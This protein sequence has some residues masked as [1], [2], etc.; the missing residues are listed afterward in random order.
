V[1]TFII[2]NTMLKQLI[3][4]GTTRSSDG[5]ATDDSIRHSVRFTVSED[6]NAD[7]P[8]G[9][10]QSP[11]PSSSNSPLIPHKDTMQSRSRSDS[12]GSSSPGSK[13]KSLHS[14]NLRSNLTRE[15]HGRD[16]LF[17]YEIVKTLGVG[18]MGSVARVKRRTNVVG[19]SARKDVQEAVRRQKRDKKCLDIPII[20]GLFR[21]CL[22]G[23]LR[24]SRHGS[25][26]GLTSSMGESM[27]SWFPKMDD[28]FTSSNG[29]APS[30]PSISRSDSHN[31]LASI[32][33]TTASGHLIQYAMKSIHLNR[34]QDSAFLTEL[35]N[36]IAILKQLDHPHIVRAIETFEHRNQI[37]IVMELCSG[38]DLYSRDPYTEEDCARIV[39]SILSAIAYMH[40]KNIL[41]RDLKFENV[42]FVNDHPKA[43]IKL[44]DFG[45][46][47]VYG[48]N[49]EL[50]EGVGTIYTMAPEVL[51]GD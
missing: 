44:I 41:H 31:S 32:E 1:T 13:R 4:R 15:Q 3:S 25:S 20:G 9:H 7:Q 45:L 28:I 27:G 10:P 12:T 33:S 36:E 39:S 40:S 2:F 30:A 17:F 24:H 14:P 46:S 16:P 51:R 26:E 49:T 43:E 22:D 42:L 6:S 35:R 47:K 19:G 8:H 21:M 29:S 48:D 18:S 5:D 23:D 37:F 11:P 50:T 38:G 34:V